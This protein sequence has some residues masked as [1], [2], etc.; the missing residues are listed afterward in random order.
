MR[1]NSL[2]RNLEGAHTVAESALATDV[3]GA[4][5]FHEFDV[6]EEGGDANPQY[7]IKIQHQEVVSINHQLIRVNNIDAIP[8][9]VNA[10]LYLLAHLYNGL[11]HLEWALDRLEVQDLGEFLDGILVRYLL[12]SESQLPFKVVFF[13]VCAIGSIYFVDYCALGLNSLMCES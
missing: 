2:H 4:E 1:V 9:L 3:L 5:L 8:K 6:S 7:D 12:G 11:D 10:Q 13:L